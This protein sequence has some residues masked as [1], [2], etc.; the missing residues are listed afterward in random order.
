MPLIGRGRVT[1]ALE[2]MSQV[3]SAVGAYNLD[4]L[5]AERAVDVP[6]HSAWDRVEESGP[7]A[8]GL[9]FLVCGVERC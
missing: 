2:Y 1:L 9:E 7:A 6:R 3:S 8:P 5:H 4:T